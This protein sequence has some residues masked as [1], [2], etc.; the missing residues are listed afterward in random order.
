INPGSVGC[1]IG[2]EAASVGILD[3]TPEKTTY[4]QVD[5]P[6]DVDHAINDMLQYSDKLPAVDYTVNRFYRILND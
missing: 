4:E 3:I 5:V 2:I 6:Y 1:P